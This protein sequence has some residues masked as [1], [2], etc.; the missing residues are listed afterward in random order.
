MEQFQDQLDLLTPGSVWK[1]NANGRLSKVLHITNTALPERVQKQH[2]PQVIYADDTGA[3]YNSGLVDFFSRYAF[4]NIDPELEQR[5]D[6]LLQ[7][8]D[9]D[10]DDDDEEVVATSSDDSAP[11]ALTKP[12]AEPNAPTKR[13]L[14][15]S[16]E[17]I[18]R[19]TK[20]LA[21]QLEE[22]LLEA[23]ASDE[24]KPGELGIDFI[25]SAGENTRLTAEQLK[26]ALVMYSQE[27]NK[28]LTLTQHRLL[29]SLGNGISLNA[30]QSA[31]I[32]SDDSSTVDA[33][34]IS[35][36][37][38]SDTVIWTEFMGVYPEV[39]HGAVYASVLVGTNDLGADTD[40]IEEHTHHGD[41]SDGATTASMLTPL[42]LEQVIA[43]TK[44]TE[45]VTDDLV[46]PQP[47]EV[48]VDVIELTLDTAQAPAPDTIDQPQTEVPPPVAQS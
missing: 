13:A 45:V 22:Q 44:A 30:L 35:T 20:T 9:D 40:E 46:T 11:L 18:G 1:K 7:F 41:E 37:Y 42:E 26:N 38:Y 19:R 32:P 33:F 5:L 23:D 29:F 31:F 36:P 6:N 48:K 47:Q 4:H 8:A 24:N 14:A 25:M 12:E 21:E 16:T 39:V 2:P 15:E 34:T 3:V 10:E 17:I 27:P 28:N 43:E